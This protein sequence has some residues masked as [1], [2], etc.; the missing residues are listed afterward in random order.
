MADNQ[1]SFRAGGSVDGEIANS[2]HKRQKKEKSKGKL[3]H[4]VHINRGGVA[5]QGKNSEEHHNFLK[6]GKK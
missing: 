6:G 5:R 4:L 2:A 3:G 1:S